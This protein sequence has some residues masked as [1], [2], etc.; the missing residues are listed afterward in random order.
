MAMP[1][2]HV[3]LCLSVAVASSEQATGR[4]AVKGN[5][6]PAATVSA[7][8]VHDDRFL[9]EFAVDGVVP[10]RDR[11]QAELG[12]V[13]QQGL[14]LFSQVGTRAARLVQIARSSNRGCDLRA[15]RIQTPPR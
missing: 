1:V 11:K 13:L 3:I 9:P 8:S 2:Q 14:D 10:P 12:R 15:V 4:A 5:L 6:A 7:T